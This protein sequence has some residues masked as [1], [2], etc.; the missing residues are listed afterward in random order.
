MQFFAGGRDYTTKMEALVQHR[1]SCSFGALVRLVCP[2]QRLD[3][4]GEK[5]TQRGGSPRGEYF[6]FANCVYTQTN[7]HVLFSLWCVVG[8]GAPAHGYD[9]LQPFYVIL[10]IDAGDPVPRLINADKRD[11]S[12]FRSR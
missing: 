4:L 2:D 8:H 9:V 1:Q 6:A 10:G 3:L 12:N 7:R 11:A 5:S